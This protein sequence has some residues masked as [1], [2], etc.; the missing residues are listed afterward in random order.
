M[1]RKDLAPHH[2]YCTGDEGTCIAGC[3]RA[4]QL[5]GDRAASILAEY[6]GMVGCE[7]EAAVAEYAADGTLVTDLLAD[8]MHAAGA[9]AVFEAAERAEHH[10]LVEVNGEDQNG[11]PIRSAR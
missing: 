4:N 5:R 7:S 2:P 6:A 3:P 8:L 11:E 1:K 10:Y 9:P